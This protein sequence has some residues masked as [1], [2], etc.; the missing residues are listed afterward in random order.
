MK[1]IIAMMLAVLMLSSCTGGKPVATVGDIKITKGEFEFYLFSIKNQMKGTELQTDEDW[2][3]QEIE[4]KKA[5]DVAK[6]RAMDIAVE[7]AMYIEAAE[8]AGLTLTADEKKKVD[9]TKVQ[10]VSGYGGEKAYK[11]FLKENNISDKFIEM[12]C[13][14]TAYYTKIGQKVNE[15]NQMSDED[16]KQY[17]VRNQAEL[18]GEIRKAKHILIMTVD[19]VTRQPKS[20]EEMAAAKVLAEDI[21]A[22]VRAGE[23]F[24]KLMNEYSEDPGLETAPDGYVF[25]SGEMVPEFEQAV[26]SVGFGKI[27]FCESDFGYHIIK[28]LPL[29]YEDAADKVKDKITEELI[30]E[31][32]EKWKEE[33]SIKVTKNEDVLKDI[34]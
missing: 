17:F 5:I 14:S 2:E 12:M 21:L 4:G 20:E 23:N 10:I 22:R 34:K 7:N 30:D 19:S 25:G 18:E 27:A 11:E 28:R 16:R 6:Q 3:T 1:K 26:D 8:A 24:D 15:E 29:S 31:Q 32:I 13:K 33:F 9:S